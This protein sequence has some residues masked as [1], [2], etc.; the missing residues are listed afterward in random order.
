MSSIAII[1]ARCGS[2]GLPD[3]NIINL[4]GK[5]VMAYTIEAA[6][7]SECFSDNVFVSTDSEEYAEIAKN[8]GA[9]V[10]MRVEAESSDSASTYDVVKQAINYLDSIG[11]TSENFAIIQPTSP[12]RN[13]KHIRDAYKLFSETNNLMDFCISMVKSSKSSSLIISIED[14]TLKNFDADFK[15]YSRHKKQEYFP[16]GA[17][18]IGKVSE[19]LERGDFFGQK[20][21]AFVM[22]EESSIDI[23]ESSDLINV[24][25]VLDNKNKKVVQKEISKKTNRT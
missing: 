9:K 11:I 8:Y 18:F 6:L 24:I 17:I 3:K 4:K 2:K 21:L 25:N 22:D 20:S 5:P 7:L 14:G 13:A 15:N 1:P 10:I 16:N 12:L 23:D 19:Y